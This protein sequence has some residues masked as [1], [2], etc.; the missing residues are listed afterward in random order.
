M[1]DF[2]SFFLFL[3]TLL[4][5]SIG[6][7]LAA[8][9]VRRSIKVWQHWSLIGICILYGIIPILITYGG[10]YLA[11]L[12]GCKADVIIYTC[13]QQP[14]LGDVISY[15]AFSYW[16]FFLTFPSAF[17][18]TLLLIIRL[19][20]RLKS[21]NNGIS[22]QPI[23]GFKRDRNH[24]IIAGV[25][26]AIAQKLGISVLLVRIITVASTVMIPM[27]ILPIYLWTWLAFPL[28]SST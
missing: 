4:I 21:S 3:L 20:Q 12:L 23:N 16:L 10:L 2:S 7:V 26:G 22:E 28:S 15:M 25:C 8:I 24:K 19:V 18:S 17:I 13:P 6:P 11:N 14:W 1:I 27:L 9:P 5:L